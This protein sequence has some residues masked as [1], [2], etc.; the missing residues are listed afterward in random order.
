MQSGQLY[1]AGG[2]FWKM[3]EDVK[4][5]VISNVLQHV[6]HI[7]LMCS[8]VYRKYPWDAHNDLA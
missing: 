3:L 7:I 1:C 8:P 5:T 2:N 6:H 4:L